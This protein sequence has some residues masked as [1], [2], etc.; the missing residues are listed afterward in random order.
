MSTRLRVY[1][2]LGRSLKRPSEVLGTT[3]MRRSR[4]KRPFA[5]WREPWPSL[6]TPVSDHQEYSTRRDQQQ[7][8][9]RARPQSKNKYPPASLYQSCLLCF[10]FRDP[11][12][13]VYH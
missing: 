12:I 8:R 13:V 6:R 4:E 11:P 5:A 10:H 3:R 9:S 2:E 1:A 7:V